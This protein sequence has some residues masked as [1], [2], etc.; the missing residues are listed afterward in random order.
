MIGVLASKEPSE[1]ARSEIEQEDKYAESDEDRL[2]ERDE[3][4]EGSLPP[5]KP[6]QR[7]HL[8]ALGDEALS[9]KR[10]V[11]KSGQLVT[12]VTELSL[13]FPYT[14][15][16]AA[17]GLFNLRFSSLTV[18]IMLWTF[19]QDILQSLASSEAVLLWYVVDS[20]VGRLTVQVR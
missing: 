2:P 7:V 19:G 6:L 13:S 9:G 14:A 3:S 12:L 20:D 1:E 18:C 11:Q 5:S 17:L 8:E 15:D 16:D 4:V 10:D